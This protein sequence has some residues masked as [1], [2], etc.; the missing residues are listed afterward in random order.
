VTRWIVPTWEAR[1]S[2][3]AQAELVASKSR[4]AVWLR[5]RGESGGMGFLSTRS[6]DILQLLEE[7]QV[8]VSRAPAQARRPADLYG[9]R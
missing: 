5:I 8:Q 6:R 1:Y 9:P 2:E 4:I 7:H 3:L